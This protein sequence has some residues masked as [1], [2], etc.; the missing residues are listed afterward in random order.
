M[1]DAMDVLNKMKEKAMKAQL[2]EGLPTKMKEKFLQLSHDMT[3]WEIEEV[4]EK[5]RK[6]MRVEAIEIYDRL[7]KKE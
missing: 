7:K 2:P 3:N 4:G 1:F 5:F 6:A